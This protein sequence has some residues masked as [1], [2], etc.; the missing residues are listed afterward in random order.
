MFQASAAINAGA[1]LF[2]KRIVAEDSKLANTLIMA[3]VDTKDDEPVIDKTT[4]DAYYIDTNGQ[5]TTNASDAD[6][7]H[8][9]HWQYEPCNLC[10]SQQAV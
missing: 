6:I 2:S 10:I 8:V 9:H 4:G 7:H 5:Y 1:R 3:I